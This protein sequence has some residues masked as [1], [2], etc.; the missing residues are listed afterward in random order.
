MKDF[1]LSNKTHWVKVSRRFDKSFTFALGF[2]GEI[3]SYRMSNI[4]KDF[5][6]SIKEAKEHAKYIL[7]NP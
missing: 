7:E 1:T 4:S 3:C 2:F 5:I 6:S